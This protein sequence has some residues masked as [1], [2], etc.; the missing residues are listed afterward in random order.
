MPPHPTTPLATPE[1][2]GFIYLGF[3]ADQAPKGPH[4]RATPRR[5][6]QAL[7]L[8]EAAQSLERWPSIASVRVFRTHLVPPLPGAPRHDLAMLLR[9][10]TVKDLAEVRNVAEVKAL[11][12][13]EVLVG[14]NAARI[15][16]TE[17]DEESIFLLNH[18]TVAGDANPVEVWRGLT[19]WY[20]SKI[21][22]DNST[23]LRSV[24][25]HSPF[26]L[27]NYVRLPANPPSFLVNQ[28]LRPSFHRVIRAALKEH[29]MRALPGFY[30][31]I[32]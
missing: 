12:G 23:A 21:H 8:I 2:H 6:Q 25:A 9:T 4:Y 3:Q 27:V 10:A 13:T 11:G 32:H 18:F 17:A 14:T 29:Q 20:T 7:H 31:M 28:L 30:R 5:R 22:V 24:D 26:A 1:P 19:D 16:N 15:G